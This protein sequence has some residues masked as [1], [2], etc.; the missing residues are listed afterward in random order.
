MVRQHGNAHEI[1]TLVLTLLS[2]VVMVLLLL[3]LSPA[4]IDALTVYDNLICVVFL[5]DF[6]Y[7]LTGSR[8]RREYF[9][10]LRGWLDLLG[11][12]PRLGILRITGLLRLARL[13]R[14]AAL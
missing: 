10:H 4:T 12:I 7:N 11:S 13:S 2:L 9:L 5:A 3:P 14:L 8:P 6:V 1:F